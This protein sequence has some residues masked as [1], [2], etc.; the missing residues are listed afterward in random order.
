MA[1]NLPIY[2]SFDVKREYAALRWKKWHERLNNVFVGY[3]I[4]NPVCRKAFML[5]FGS[6]D[7]DYATFVT[8]YLLIALSLQRMNELQI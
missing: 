4:A 2:P 1:F 8:V 3:D 6:K 7:L 5:F